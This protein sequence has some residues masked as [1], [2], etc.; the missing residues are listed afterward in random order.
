MWERVCGRERELVGERESRRVRG[1]VCVGET[2]LKGEMGERE[3]V[4]ERAGKREC[5]WKRKFVGE[6]FGR[7]CGRECGRESVGVSVWE[8]ERACGR[9]RECVWERP[10]GRESVLGR[11]RE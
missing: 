9:E 7:E 11:E 6:S 8:R 5:V 1:R 3:S 2:V 10:C 4:G